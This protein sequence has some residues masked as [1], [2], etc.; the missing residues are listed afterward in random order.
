SDKQSIYS[1]Q[2][3]SRSQSPAHRGAYVR[4]V[5]SGVRVSRYLKTKHPPLTLHPDDPLSAVLSRLSDATYS[6]LPVV[7]DENRLLGVVNLE[8]VHLAAQATHLQPLILA[9]D[10]M[11]TDVVPLQPG[12]QL[13]R[14]LELFV[15]ND[16]FALPVVNDLQRRRLIGMVRRFEIASAYLKH[17]HGSKSGGEA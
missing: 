3:E 15:E 14:A 7:D 13:D 12:D 2:V 11:R 8:E 4:Q 9:A 1:A 10:L 17:M 16:L 5:L 6:V